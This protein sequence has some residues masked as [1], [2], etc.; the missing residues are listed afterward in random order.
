[1]KKII[2][3]GT[4]P[5]VLTLVG[6]TGGGVI[7]SH[8]DITPKPE[9]KVIAQGEDGVPWEL[10]ENGYLLFKPVPGKDT[11]TNRDGDTSWKREH[12][13][14]I[15]HVGFAGKVYAPVDSSRLFSGYLIRENLKFNP[16]T[17]NTTNLDTSKVTDMSYMFYY[18]NNLTTLDVTK[19]DTSKVVD[20]RYMFNGMANLTSLDVTN[21]KTSKV[22]DMSSMFSGLSK[23]TSLN[24]TKL[25]TSN[26][27]NM[28]QMFQGMNNLTSLDVTNFKTS[29]VTDMS[30]MFSGL[31]KLTSLDV[32]KLDT[33]NVTNMYFMFQGMSE[34]TS[35]DVTKFKTGNVTDMSAMFYRVSKL[36]T[37]DVTKFD[38]S[39]VTK[40]NSMF[41]D[42]SNLTA[43]DVTNFKTGK[44]QDM[45]SMFSGVS[46]LKTLDVTHFDTGNVT[47]MHGM[48]QDMSSLKTLDVTKF[49]TG[50][51][52]NMW[53]M[54]TR[55][56]NLTAL[57]VTKFDTRK[58]TNMVDMFN[59][60]TNLTTLDITNFDTTSVQD[61]GDIFNNMPKLKEL[62]LGNKFKSNGIETIDNNRWTNVP[63]AYGN[64]Y[65]D[66]WHKI[67]DKAHPYTVEDWANLYKA[68]PSGTAGTWVREE[69]PNT[70]ATLTFEGEN[71]PP[72]KVQAPT[73]TLPDLPRPHDPKPNK[74]FKGWSRTP[75]GAPIDPTSIKPGENIT[76]HPIWED[77]NNTKTRTEKIPVTTIYEADPNLDYGKQTETPG[78]EG[79]KRIT[80]TYTVTPYT[81]ELTNP[82]DKE[83][84]TKQMKPKV[85]K[86]GTKPKT[87]S[88]PI[89]SPI[90]Y[91]I[92]KTRDVGTK[93][94]ETPGKK[95]STS[96][97]TTY[98]VDPKTGKVTEK[99]GQPVRVEPT[100]IIIKVGGR[101]KV[102]TTPIKSPI[103]YVLDKNKPRT[104][105]KETKP[106]KEGSTITTI[107]HN[108]DPNTGK[109]TE[110]PPTTQTTPPTKT[111]ITVGGRDDEETEVIPPEI[112]YVPDD[113]NSGERIEGKPGKK[114]TP[115]T[116]TIDPRTGDV[117][118]HKGEPIITPPTKTI[119]K[120]GTKDTVKEEEIP[121]KTRYEANPNKE[122]GTP[123]EVIQGKPGKKITITAH[124]V[125][126]KTGKITDNVRPPV[127]TD[128]IDTVIKVGAK[129]KVTTTSTPSPI[130]YVLDKN[131][132]RTSPNE[133]KPG[134][135]GSTITTINYTVDP[136]TGKAVPGTP[137]TETTPPTKTIITV[138]GRDDEE[139]EVIPP[140]IEYVPDDTN[141][142]ETI[143]GKP[144]K[145]VTPI[146]YTIDPNTGTV[147]PHKGE[148]IITPPTKTIIK[149]STKPKVVTEE[150]EPGT[151]YE[152]DP[153]RDKGT[154]N[155]TIPGKKGKKVTTT[156][157][158]LDKATG[159]TIEHTDKP[160]IT[161]PV[162]TII[163]VGT[164]TKVITEIIEPGIEYVRDDNNTGEKIQGKP[165][166]KVITITYTVDPNTGNVTENT[167]KP[168]ITP[169]INTIVKIGTK[170]DVINEPIE[171]G[172]T[173]EGDDTRDANT[174]NVTIPGKQGK[175]TTLITYELEP[176]TGKRI[177]KRG[178]PT[179]TPPINTIVK[180]GTKPKVVTKVIEPE[181]IYEGDDTRNA[182][183][184]NVTIPGKKGFTSTT[185]TYTVDPKT[186]KLTEKTTEKNEAPGKT[187]VKVGSKPKVVTQI[188][189]PEVLYEGDVTRDTNTPNVTIPGTKGTKT[190]TTTYTVDPKTGKPTE[191]VT[192]SGTKPGTTRIK[193]GTK[194][195][196]KRVTDPNGDVYEETTTYTV[197]PKTGKVTPHT[198]RK[199]IS[200]AAPKDP[201][202]GAK[203]S[204][205]IDENGNPIKPPVL[206]VPEYTGVLAGNGLDGEGNIIEPP[207]LEVPE[208]TGVIAGNGLDG[209]GNIIEPPVLEVPEYKGDTTEKPKKEPKEE[210]KATVKAEPK[211][212]TKKKLPETGDSNPAYLASLAVI[213]IGLLRRKRQK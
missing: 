204:N 179:I 213:G 163:K 86:K 131:K 77:V 91:V 194:P 183:T 142:G 12:G 3:L 2:K 150:I 10:H 141:A 144:G 34:L 68:N 121:N 124:T 6:L 102:T 152:A 64:Q 157:Y 118:P 52:K 17:I 61:I 191:K 175:K 108:V 94:E 156:T 114:V 67:N 196:V 55:T 190:T 43:L 160:V 93:N 90:E 29:N 148:P 53:A 128:P 130:E 21:F 167:G 81:G 44:V 58:V 22:S 200:K 92:D 174:P 210:P 135:A 66:K 27:R 158:T 57:D 79:E 16:L 80:T 63:H 188:I 32:T 186:G 181:V 138:G 143:P 105:P 153:S 164:K 95:G 169:P 19:F 155:V 75:G 97:T 116:Y 137:V 171:P 123:N 193:V 82:H 76:L 120:V 9:G 14:K 168:E 83:E 107:T 1:M 51:V 71:F 13:E 7:H 35:L 180:V 30:S 99:Q 42:M 159:K 111:I 197:D 146:T 119:V 15:K 203:A 4:V 5:A 47:N 177:E 117:T 206:D 125:D 72:I 26:V 60:M 139:T 59:G 48:F 50:N 78:V 112:E 192:E 100:K 149:V 8:A 154:P 37:L 24:V 199:L 133:T 18:L 136:N 41:A 74:K 25:D 207:V 145:K 185:T 195:T 33:S 113:T 69:K 23:L 89:D 134:K 84:I 70:E 103:E 161:P 208:Y 49:K 172:V 205:G 56:S 166:K 184:P 178:T 127:I 115:I 46:K 198:I 73:T 189:E 211:Q 173:Y 38:T 20:M 126:P 104:S 122:V 96:I 202:D 110:N 170:D 87:T 212:E 54:F 36:V 140:E 28:N 151:R 65:T 62:K 147:T 11:L 162:D 129:P 132:P 176:S 182:N 31:S 209:E 40:M 165:G 98:T 45:G 39:N 101:D 106:G 109:V 85:I 201:N 187:I 88:T